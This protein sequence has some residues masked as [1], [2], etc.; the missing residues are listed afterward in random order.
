MVAV[1]SVSAGALIGFAVRLV[2]AALTG[3]ISGPAVVFKLHSSKEPCD[4]QGSV[5]FLLEWLL[6]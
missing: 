2:K 3:L 5:A 4:T 6:I 1:R